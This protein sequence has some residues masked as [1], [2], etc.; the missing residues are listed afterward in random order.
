MAVSEYDKKYLTTAQQK[1]IQRV[2]DEATAG[3]ISWADAHSAAESIRAE[4]GYSGGSYGNS[5]TATGSGSSGKASSS[6]SSSSG[7]ASS[8]GSSSSG[9]KSYAVDDYGQTDYST[10]IRDA[11]S[12]GAGADT[13][14]EL[15]DKRVSKAQANG[16]NQYLYD[17]VYAA[18]TKYIQ[19][20]SALNAPEYESPYSGKLEELLESISKMSYEDWVNGSDYQA[21]YN[22]Y[23]KQG[24]AGMQNVLGQV[25]SRTGGLASSYAATAAQQ[26]YNDY[27]SQLET[28]A[29]EM[30][31]GERSDLMEDLDLYRTLENDSYNKYLGDLSQW[32]S[33]RTFNYNAWRDSV[34]DSRYD[35]EWDYNVGRDEVSDSRYDQEWEYNA[36]RDDISDERYDREYADSMAATDKAEAQ[37]RIST[38]LASGGKAAD[39][40]SNLIETSG[41]TQAELAALESYYAEQKALQKVSL[42]SSGSSGGSSGSSTAS[43][44]VLTAAQ[45][46]EALKDGIVNNSTLAA[47]EYYYGQAWSNADQENASGTVNSGYSQLTKELSRVEDTGLSDA[48]KANKITNLIENYLKQGSITEAQAVILLRQYGLN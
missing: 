38:Y 48:A 28:V 34:S 42:S 41:Y 19:E 35:K 5:Y 46:L 37:E 39:L 12:A 4:A 7:K 44:P 40:D 8:S 17:D 10:L 30:Y 24:Q 21:L 6:G 20:Q 36:G 47:Y 3:K 15:L 45:T 9:S 13:V 14:Q 11:M 16:Y 18:A 31:A 1:E 33:D 32:N 22:R 23:A 29:R 26:Q 27:M 43:K 2:T 25:A